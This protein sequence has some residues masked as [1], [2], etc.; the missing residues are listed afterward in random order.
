MKT[1][2]NLDRLFIISLALLAV[3]FIL[4]LIVPDLTSP[5]TVVYDWAF[6]MSMALGYFGAFIIS[7]VGNTT[8]LFPIPYM[9]FPFVL[10][11][12]T[13][14]T[15]GQFL[16]DPLIIGIISGFGAMLGEMTGYLIGYGGGQLI[17]ENIQLTIF[18]GPLDF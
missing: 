11:G 9:L 5:I 1:M 8:I 17:E 6:D 15:T 14:N 12:L 2:R 16:F 10:G 7:F 18:Q 13:D 4:S 3:Y